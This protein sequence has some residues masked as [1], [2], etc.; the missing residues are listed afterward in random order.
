MS[1]EF[2]TSPPERAVLV[3]GSG[4]GA[5]KAADDVA[6][7]GIPLVWATRAGHFLELPDGIGTFEEWPE[8]LNFQFRPLYLRVKNHWLT[9]PL[10]RARL[11][12]VE[13]TAHGYRLTIR[14]DPLYIDY[15]LCTGCSRCMEV[16]PLN[17]SECPPL[18]RTP[19][20]CP[21]RALVLDKRQLGACRQA[22][23]LGVNVQGY[24]A[25]TAAGRFAEA[26]AVIR[27]DNPLPGICGRVCH[28][29][30]EAECRRNDVDQPV[31][32]RD[33]KRFLFDYEAEQGE[34]G[35]L[36]NPDRKS[37]GQ[38]VAVVGSGPAG[39][40][41]AHFLNRAGFDVTIFEALSQAGGMLRAGINAFRL[42][43]KVLD[44]EIE[45]LEKS[46]IKI[47]TNTAIYSVETLLDQ[48][49]GVV[50]LATG[51]HQDLRLG[52]EGE[53]L[54]GV[55]HC[56]EFLARVNM[57]GAT[58][59]GRRTVVIGGGNS[60]M[61]A[62]RTAL[63]L[64]A[65]EVTVL[66]IEKE[67]ELPAHPQEVREAREEGVK[68][69]LG[70]APVVFKGKNRIESLKAHPA[71]WEF[72]ETGPPKLVFDG[73][74]TFKMEADTIIVAIGQR[75][76]LDTFRLVEEV[77]TDRGGRLVVGDCLEC[78][79]PGVFAA[80]DVVTGPTTVVGSMAGGRR[81]AA[82]IIEYLTGEP[83]P[84]SYYGPGHRGVGDWVE[85]DDETPRRPRFEKECRAP[86]LRCRDFE[87][88]D[89]GFTP[90][91]AMAEGSRCLQCGSCCECRACE[92]ACA[93]IGAIDHF[94]Q[95][96]TVEFECSAVIV[97]DNE[98]LPSDLTL[99]EEIIYRTIERQK[100]LDL[101]SSLMAGAAAAGETIA[102]NT[103]LRTILEP[104]ALEPFTFAP[105]ERFGFFLCT[106]NETMAPLGALE[107]IRNL[108][109]QVPGIEHSELLVS[110]CH[111][112]GA[113]R[114]ARVV[115]E[116]NLSR[117][118]MASCVCCPLQ[119]QCIACNEQRHRA[120][121][122][123]FEKHGL[124]RSRFEMINLRDHLNK[125]QS[126]DEIVDRARNL[127][128]GAFIRSRFLGPLRQ[129]FTEIGDRIL[130]LGGSEVGVSCA[131][132]LDCQGYR[133]RL[134]HRCRLPEAADETAGRPINPAHGRAIIQVDE[135]VI[136]EIRGS[137]GNF[138]VT[139]EEAGVRKHWR[140]DVVC[141]T[142][143]N[144]LPLAVDTGK[145]GLKK[146]YRYNFSFFHSP[147]A[148]LYRVRPVT[149]GRVSQ[150]QAGAALAAEVATT[151]A[152]AFLK[153]HQLSPQVDPARC[154]GCGRCQEICPFG[155]IRLVAGPEGAYTAEVLH[156]NCVGC[157]GCVGRC[158]VT[159]LDMPYFSNQLLKELV[160]GTMAGGW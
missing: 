3:L 33:I 74:K 89:F 59:V 145:T 133:V 8:D 86:D 129:G 17:E 69:R 159:A 136:H 24:M 117:V 142:D 141:L 12:A 36:S 138:T 54:D 31:A 30:C 51:T 46:G 20:Y 132:N 125:N 88:V 91:Q 27:E 41:A 97:A 154:R 111:P 157:G 5:L 94:R 81:A 23:P 134:V 93:A 112:K 110:A 49:F 21:S 72:S 38:R 131:E 73:A 130:V 143:E 6:Q 85:I 153:D 150:R 68:F 15:D 105:E 116:K 156:H 65:E 148:G 14:Q 56:V 115:E 18:S 64:G 62:A 53:K 103:S 9:T 95:G 32:I 149:L 119:F 124:S 108:A 78:S 122:N 1:G 22:C 26:L 96:R 45:I 57:I 43:R 113:E 63:R 120:K 104:E 55:E 44:A 48:G 42:P 76:H 135:A 155:A 151:T 128:R 90:E 137:L 50:L 7:S 118:I 127:L 107:R 144:L 66:A 140:A 102:K 98:E 84:E 114:L 13:K 101:M 126:E 139:V 80:G 19:D 52:L 29:P 99:P 47:K 4:F 71:H 106:C 35:G 82:R 40:T 34:G 83:A 123:L 152:E 10:P 109:E 87:E 61:D 121:I 60:A 58:R 39:L 70:A 77:E 92:E 100:G 67:D 158:P 25:L 75:P 147:H 37:R 79:R 146:F 28:H 2:K 11:A 16:C 160:S